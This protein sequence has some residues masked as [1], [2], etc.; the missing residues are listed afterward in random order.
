MDDMEAFVRRLVDEIAPRESAAVKKEM[1]RDMSK[2]LEA[3]INRRVMELVPQHKLP[4]FERVLDD[5]NSDPTAYLQRTIPNF[6]ERVA[7]EMLAFRRR[8]VR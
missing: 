3:S 6:S 5:P 8:Y 4:E 2:S 1:I 7:E